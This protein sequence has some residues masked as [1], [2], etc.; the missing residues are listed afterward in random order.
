MLEVKARL[1]MN[2]KN[3]WGDYSKL[4]MT[5]PMHTKK[6]IEAMKEEA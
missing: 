2:C 3:E 1:E 5:D 6:T 4:M